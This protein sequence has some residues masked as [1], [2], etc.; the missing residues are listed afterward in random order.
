MDKELLSMEGTITK[1]KIEDGWAYR[2]AHEEIAKI[3][4]DI[5]G[6]HSLADLEQVR[7]AYLGRKDG[8]IT[9]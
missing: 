4:D 9:Q 5:E 3:T 7:I 1:E 2:I 8:K 6:C